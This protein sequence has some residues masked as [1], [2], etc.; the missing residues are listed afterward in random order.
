MQR[1][2]TW[3]QAEHS[4]LVEPY[5]G[6]PT[7]GP[8]PEALEAEEAGQRPQPVTAFRSLCT[9]GQEYAQGPGS[10]DD[11]RKSQTAVSKTNYSGTYPGHV[12][13]LLFHHSCEKVSV[14]E[15]S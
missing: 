3:S 7:E 15:V 8:A 10:S 14:R 5:P 2:E 4:C 12:I 11:M 9:F 1:G 6:P 13:S